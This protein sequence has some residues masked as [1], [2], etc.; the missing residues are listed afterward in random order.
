MQHRQVQ[1][2]FDIATKIAISKYDRRAFLFGAI[3]IRNDGAKV[4]AINSPTDFPNRKAH[5]EYKLCRKLDA[6]SIIFIVRIR[7]LDGTFA[8][9]R[10]C[11][12]CMKILKSKKINKAFYTIDSNSYGIFFPESNTDKIFSSE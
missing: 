1:R 6:N 3:G 12:D 9:A 5:V 10:P 11:H 7:L 2:Y 4:Q 8:M